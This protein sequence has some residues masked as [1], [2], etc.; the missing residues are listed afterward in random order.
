ME[1]LHVADAISHI[2]TLAR[3]ANKYIDETMPWALSRDPSNL[4]RLQSVLYHLLETI[5][6]CATLLAP[7]FAADLRADL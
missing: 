7:F 2:F 6:F 3:R 1:G 5:R 4:P